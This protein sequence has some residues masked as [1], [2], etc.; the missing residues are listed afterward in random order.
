MTPRAFLATARRVLT[1]LMHDPRT[2]ALMIVVPSVLMVLLRYVFDSTTVFDH[3]A[4]ALLGFFPFLMMFLITSIT[5][6]RERTSGTLERL[7]TTTMAK[8][9]LLAGY[10]IAF[11][12]FAVVQVV[13]ATVVVATVVDVVR[14]VLVVESEL[15]LFESA[16]M[17]PE[18]ITTTTTNTPLRRATPPGRHRHDLDTPWRDSDMGQSYRSAQKIP[19]ADQ[20]LTSRRRTSFAI[21]RSVWHRCQESS[22]FDSKFQN[23]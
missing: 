14:D 15:P 16:K 7:L 17:K 8:I 1:Q 12:A 6:L 9:D 22:R 3:L 18:A 20:C 10:A 23:A 11:S 2:I 4:P 19:R 21:A 5:M 13:V